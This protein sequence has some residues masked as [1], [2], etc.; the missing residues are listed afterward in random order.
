M[1]QRLFSLFFPW[2]SIE[3]TAFLSF[4][5]L[6]ARLVSR[7]VNYRWAAGPRHAAA[8]AVAPVKS[9]CS[10]AF[11]STYVQFLVISDNQAS[12][13]QP[14][15]SHQDGK[16]TGLIRTVPCFPNINPGLILTLKAFPWR[17]YTSMNKCE[18]VKEKK[19]TKLF[20]T[21]TDSFCLCVSLYS[22][23]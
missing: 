18:L 5:V 15:H 17:A 12:L 7:P 11:R 2:D 9:C 14:L 22:D 19:G 1:C 3:A 21:Q 10:P 23:F 16:N 13:S 4:N 8:P 20:W 6:S